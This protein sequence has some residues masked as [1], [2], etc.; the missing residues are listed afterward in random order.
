M[1]IGSRISGWIDALQGLPEARAMRLALFVW[2]VYAVIIA[3]IV[4][5]QPDR[6]TVTPEYRE[7]CEEWWGGQDIYEVRMH[8]YLYLPHAAIL[9]TPFA[10]LPVRVGEPLWRLVSLGLLAWSIW[11]LARRFGG[12]RAGLWFLI[13]TVSALPASF[14]AA[15]NGQMN[16]AMA[17]LLALAAMDLGIRAWNRSSLWLLLSL[18]FKPLGLVPCLLAGGCYPRP[19]IWRLGLG[20]MLMGAVIF[21]H[22]NPEYVASQYE[23]FVQTMQIAGK[24]KQPLFCDVQGML[25]FFGMPLPDPV[26]TAVRALAAIGTLLVA[27]LGLRRYDA[28]RGAFVCMLLAAWYL[29]LFN[30]RTETNSYI[31]LA[32]FAGILVASAAQNPKFPGRFLALAVFALILSCENWGPLHKLTNLWLKAAAGLVFGVFLIRDVLTGRNPMELPA[33]VEERNAGR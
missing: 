8:G 14:S 32:P 19:M 25:L 29:L 4:A 1:N 11:R 30:P 10:A 15:R 2:A 31:L 23:L 27:W 9:Y 5:V 21:L 18:A 7:A 33:S 12:S 22:S 24:P 20:G 28:A 16:L 3:G 13:A 26:M 6:R 17:A